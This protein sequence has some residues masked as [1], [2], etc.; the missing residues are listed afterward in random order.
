MAAVHLDID[1]LLPFIPEMD[2]LKAELMIEDAIALA[3]LYAPCIV[4]GEDLS[5]ARAAAAK[6]IIRR[7]IIRLEDAGSGAL[8]STQVSAGPFQQSDSFDTRSLGMNL[9][10]RVEADQLRKLC[11]NPAAR[12]FSVDMTPDGGGVGQTRHSPECSYWFDPQYCSCGAV[13]NGQNGGPLW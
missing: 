1:D 12:G 3:G 6:S 10:T 2:E 13:L 8:S 9:F 4:S 7:A 11:D 5:E